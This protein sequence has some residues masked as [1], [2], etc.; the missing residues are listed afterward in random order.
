MCSEPP[1][2]RH[3]YDSVAA[4][5]SS[6]CRIARTDCMQ[7]HLHHN[8]MYPLVKLSYE[9]LPTPL[10]IFHGILQLSLLPL[11]PPALPFACVERGVSVACDITRSRNVSMTSRSRLLRRRLLLDNQRAVVVTA[12][13]TRRAV[14]ACFIS[15]AWLGVSAQSCRSASGPVM[16]LYI[17]RFAQHYS[18]RLA[19]RSQPP[20][21]LDLGVGDSFIINLM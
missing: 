9:I 8:Y 16:P 2:L 13:K 19:A 11:P 10:C 5:S 17:A 12:A 7:S 6:C 1:L 14:S 20:E 3:C 18:P 15:M 21:R 4:S